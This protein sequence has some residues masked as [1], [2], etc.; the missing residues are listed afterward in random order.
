MTC[1]VNF[2]YFLSANLLLIEILLLL[3]LSIYHLL[4]FRDPEWID[5]K[6]AQVKYLLLRLS[7]F[8]E[9]VSDK[10]GCSP[11]VIVAGDFNS[12]PGDEVCFHCLPLLSFSFEKFNGS[13]KFS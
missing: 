6:L 2:I 5:V 12:M 13:G 4:Y 10:Y 7:Q 1:L 8:K 3:S 9:L 11:S